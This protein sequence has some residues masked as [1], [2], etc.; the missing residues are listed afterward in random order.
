MHHENIPEGTHPMRKD[1]AWNTRL[2]HASVPY[3]MHRVEG[4]GIYEIPVGPIHAGI[5]EPGHFRFN[6]RGERILSLEGKL[7]FKHKGVEKL[8]EGKTPG[9]ALAFVE[10]V[11]G[12]MVVGHAL[13]YVQAVEAAT[14]TEVPPRVRYLR[15]VYNEL[16]RI[17]MHTFDIGNIAGMGTG[18]TFMVAQCFRL[19]E[20]LRRLH[21]TLVGHRFLRGAVTLG[22]ARDLSDA[23][24]EKIRA[25]LDALERELEGIIQ[26]AYASDGLMERFDMTGILSEEAA[27]AYG[28]DGVAARASGVPIDARAD[29]P[30]AAYRETGVTVVTKSIGDVSARFRVR[31]KELRESLRIIRS[32]LDSLPKGKCETAIVPKAGNAYGVSEAWRGMVIDWVRLDE[33]GKIDRLVIRDPS[34]MN[35]PLFGELAPGN[36]VPDFPLCNKSLSLSYSGTDL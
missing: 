20:K 14:G 36:I 24:I 35:W 22:G 13:P 16:E 32:A 18:F 23:N 27:R 5:I 19:V 12:D 9:E 33:A 28:A 25:T 30:Y 10:R 29:H 6:V 31:V 15:T 26:I 4:R 21:E 17:I 11:S 34:F 1:F 3:P 2:A 8:V 7:F